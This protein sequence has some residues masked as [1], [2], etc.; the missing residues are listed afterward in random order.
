MSFC[1]QSWQ[2]S[3]FRAITTNNDLLSPF[4]GKMKLLREILR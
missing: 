2:V 3:P 4:S 1:V